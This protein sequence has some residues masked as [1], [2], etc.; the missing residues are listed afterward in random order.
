V[1]AAIFTWQGGGAT[2]PA[3]GI[4]R[5]LAERGHEVRVVGPAAYAGR[6][7]AAGCAYSP[8]PQSLEFDTAKGRAAEDQASYIDE[9]LLGAGP[10]QALAAELERE[11]VDVVVID[12]LMRSAICRAESLGVPTV[13]FL[14]MVHRFHGVPQGGDEEWGWRWTYRQ[15]NEV[16]QGFG[17]EPLP[18][19]PETTAVALARRAAAALVAMPAE[20]DLW[21]DEPPPNLAHV[22]PIFEERGAPAWEP[23]WP[24][25]DDRPLAVVSMGSTYMHQEELLT[26]VAGVPAELGMRVLVLTGSEL[27]AEEIAL[28]PDV[29]VRDFVPHRAIFPQADLVVT[30]AGMGTLMAAFTAGVPVL[31]LPLGRDQNLNGE[32]VEELQLG[33]VLPP[34]AS[35]EQIRQAAEATVSSAEIGTAVEEMEA[36]IAAYDT[37]AMIA[38][39]IE[40]TV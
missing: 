12:Y 14:H 13:L 37:E 31:C 22:G 30:H 9:I 6:A 19:G 1:K 15:L 34:D 33:S 18:L 38:R 36:A 39:A 4:G 20:F 35:P 24:E 27:G 21:A 29:V 16:R 25:D 28:G 40:A 23:P 2:Q 26:R 17:L 7:E 5:V 8:L 10:P 11:P 3:F 32:L